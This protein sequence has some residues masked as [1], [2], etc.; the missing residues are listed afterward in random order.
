M[1]MLK[2]MAWCALWPAGSWAAEGAKAS[3]NPPSVVSMESMLQVALSLLL[4]LGVVV[5]VAWLLKRFQV[6][7]KGTGRQIKL[8]GS[9]M[10]GQR[11]RVVLVEVP[12]ARLLLGVAP[13]QVRMLHALPKNEMGRPDAD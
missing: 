13:G 8:I 9:V 10:V 4:V 3:Y 2:K 12:E 11:E 6:P 7:Q 1:M 5:L